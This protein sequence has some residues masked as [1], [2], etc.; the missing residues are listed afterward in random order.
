M[1]RKLSTAL[2]IEQAGHSRV[3]FCLR[4]V[5]HM[6]ILFRMIFM[7]F[8]VVLIFTFLHIATFLIYVLKQRPKSEMA[9]C[10]IKSK[11]IVFQFFS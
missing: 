9:Y 11:V 4:S 8:E 6:K 5:I 2:R 7:K 1:P 3:A 10:V